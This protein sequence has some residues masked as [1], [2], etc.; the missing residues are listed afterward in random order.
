[1]R[2]DGASEPDTRLDSRRND[3]T[4]LSCPCLSVWNR[5]RPADLRSRPFHLRAAGLALAGAAEP[6]ASHPAAAFAAP[7][8]GHPPDLARRGRIC[9]AG[10]RHRPG[11]DG[12]RGAL[13]GRRR[14]ALC[15][16]ALHTLLDA[17][18][19]GLLQPAARRGLRPQR[20][21]R[22]R[23]RLHQQLSAGA[24]HRPADGRHRHRPRGGRQPAPGQR[25]GA[26]QD[27]HTPALRL[28]PARAHRR[29]PG[30]AARPRGLL[31][32]R[33][34]GAQ[35]DPQPHLQPAHR[36]S[37]PAGRRQPAAALR[38]TPCAGAG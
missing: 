31:L 34:P 1:M 16:A 10:P 24:G 22:R 28:R 33:I 7:G 35:G 38:S 18:R 27:R 36:R 12:R 6:P 26:A 4:L 2:Y 19:P 15:G 32:S 21:A 13:P 14:S 11:S 8:V 5:R 30:Q 9:A 20:A 23:A 17:G 29:P 25:P 37:A 3:D